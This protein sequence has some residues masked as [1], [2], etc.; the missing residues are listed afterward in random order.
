MLPEMIQCEST[1]REIC[2]GDIIYFG[3]DNSFWFSNGNG[4]LL[5]VPDLGLDEVR[6]TNE[7]EC[8]RFAREL[9][10]ARDLGL[11]SPMKN[12]EMVGGK[13][14]FRQSFERP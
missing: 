2:P 4:Q 14:F 5:V 12:T 3:F 8:L 10:V 11:S 6:L 13:I 7:R 1:T 9:A